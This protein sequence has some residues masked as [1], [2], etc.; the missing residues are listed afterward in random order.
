M[1]WATLVTGAAGARAQTPPPA[2]Q[3]ATFT[4][5]TGGW[6]DFGARGTWSSGD[7]DR[8][9]RFRDLGDGG[10]LDRLRWTRESS[11]YLFHAEADNA[12]RR[13][14]RYLGLFEQTGKLRASFQ[15]DQIPLRISSDTRTPYTVEGP[16]VLRLED[17]IQRGIE[18]GQLTLAAV[19][20]LAGTFETD[21]RR[22][23]ADARIWFSPREDVDIRGRVSTARK[24][25]WMPWG[26]PFG[27]NLA[28]EVPAPI[29]HRTTDARMEVEWTQGT[30]LLRVSYDG[31]WFQNDIE[32]LI[33]DNPIRLTD[34]T[35]PNAY[36][37][38]NG[39]SSGRMS[40]WPSNQMHTVGAA[41]SFAL[42]R[43]TR[44]TANVA[45]GAATQNAEVLPHT[46]NTAIPSLERARER[47]DADAR[48][49]VANV[50]MTS[51][52]ARGWS[53]TARYRLH[54]R[55]NET[56][57]FEIDRRVRLDQVAEPSEHGPEFFSLTRQNID[58]EA[59]YAPVRFTSV[60]VGYAHARLDRTHRIFD[61]TSENTIRA[62]VDTTG[63]A[64]VSLRAQVE[65]SARTGHDFDL[66]ALEAVGEQPGMRHYDVA[67]R[68]RTRF[69]A[70]ATVTP[71]SFAGINA[72]ITV[73]NDDYDESLFGLREN[74]HRVYS[75]GFDLTAAAALLSV[76]YSHER[77]DSFQLSRQANPGEQ[78]TNP[79][80]DWG[81]DAGE[82]VNSILTRLELGPIIP[83][84]QVVLTYDFS[85]SET[86]YLYELGSPDAERTLPEGSPVTVL[87]PVSQ[88][89]QVNNQ[90]HTA[91]LE[92]RYFLN[93]RF[94]VGFVYLYEQYRVEDFAL[95]DETIRRIDLPNGLLMYYRYRP[96]DAHSLWARITYVF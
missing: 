41:G 82:R 55:D 18:A 96:Y 63:N 54:D 67:D 83:R 39:T 61:H 87:P 30:S 93:S 77:Y 72:A 52:P 32:R 88:L 60:R 70:M 42:P 57:P 13:D 76:S 14:Q 4:S 73:G 94:A 19:V 9:Q 64:Y 26:A 44:V 47:A 91:R 34:S 78:F 62:S 66:E 27:F 31:S 95:G 92:T 59:A 17:S 21:Y 3:G 51:R 48:I 79:L 23:I 53:F 28:V 71:V 81:I 65:R 5:Q 80:R 86:D 37:A 36:V 56:A 49:S 7:E 50:A 89:P 35:N 22:D 90:L 6:V 15:W 20:P 33:W 25:G 58:L 75:A 24:E 8:F 29:D 38:G 1:M 11:L 69:T 45:L 40:L 46:I 84:T 43:R 10:F 12:G 74:D 16:G 85:R 68:D 2:T